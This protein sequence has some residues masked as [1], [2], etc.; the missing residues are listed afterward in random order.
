LSE[1]SEKEETEI[2]RLSKKEE[3]LRKKEEQLRKKEE[4]LREEK[5]L[6]LGRSDYGSLSLGLR[7]LDLSPSS[8]SNISVVSSPHIPEVELHRPCAVGGLDMTKVVLPEIS[9]ILETSTSLWVWDPTKE[10]FSWDPDKSFFSSEAD[11]SSV[12]LQL[13]KSVILGLKK[14]HHDLSITLQQ[15]KS[16]SG[17]K[18][19]YWIFLLNGHLVGCVEVKKPSQCT[20]QAWKQDPLNNKQVLGQVYDYMGVIRS[21]YGTTPVWGIVTTF[22]E[23]RFCKLLD[24]AVAEIF[25]SPRRQ[26]GGAILSATSP[27]PSF[28]TPAKDSEKQQ[29]SPPRVSLSSSVSGFDISVDEAEEKD[30]VDSEEED[31][32]MWASE[33]YSC[34]DHERLIA[35]LGGVFLE[36]SRA[37]TSIMRLSSD[38]ICHRALLF[39]TKGNVG[40]GWASP[41]ISL[42]WGRFVGTGTKRVF[43]IDDLGHGRDGRVWLVCN[44]GGA[45]GVL[46]FVAGEVEA[47]KEADC[48][49]KVYSTY[50]WSNQ[51]ASEKWSKRW[52]VVMPR[53][54]QF[55]TRDERLEALELIEGVLR[56]NFAGNTLKHGDVKWR[57]IGYFLEDDTMRVILFDL[58]HVPEETSSDWVAD[59]MSYLKDNA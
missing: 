7:K 2:A 47:K 50:S 19:D 33:V 57:N 4:Q 53:F 14:M 15:E 29:G 44:I 21:F 25:D 6:L 22:N 27:G 48:W 9:T 23:W 35:A 52:A 39:F 16:I 24:A 38:L 55:Y 28:R 18:S 5:K 49:K 45:L 41:N 12:V 13:L 56:E 36:M 30:G 31:R 51:V 10:E 1:R 42:Q 54:R 17:N 34:E 43:A 58:S 11:V 20:S 46:K 37:K 40:L 8:S 3:Q 32:K 26:E 59:A